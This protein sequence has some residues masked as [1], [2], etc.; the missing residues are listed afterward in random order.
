MKTV[1]DFWFRIGIGAALIV[2]GV[3]VSAAT[4]SGGGVFL[5]ALGFIYL[6]WTVT[7]AYLI[8]KKAQKIQERRPTRTARASDPI[9][10]RR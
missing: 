4:Q 5:M 9:R 7:S 2:L 6:A 3:L 8:I 1:G 10:R